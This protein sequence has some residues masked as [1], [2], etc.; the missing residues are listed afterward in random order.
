MSF[1]LGTINYPLD[2]KKTS[3]NP[4]DMLEYYTEESIEKYGALALAIE[5]I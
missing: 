4:W 2:I 1:I 3:L 5:L